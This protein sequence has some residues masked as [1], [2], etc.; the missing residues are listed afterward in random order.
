MAVLELIHP[1]LELPLYE[2]RSHKYIKIIHSNCFV[3]N[4]LFSVQLKQGNTK[5]SCFTAGP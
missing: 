1:V 2:T 3:V 5:H 4:S